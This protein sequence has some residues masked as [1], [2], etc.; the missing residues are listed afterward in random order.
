MTRLRHHTPKPNHL[1]SAEIAAALL[2]NATTEFIGIRQALLPRRFAGR[3][4][5]ILDGY[6]T[7]KRA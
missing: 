1:V 5:Q 4:A 6:A 3:C 2:V 7:I